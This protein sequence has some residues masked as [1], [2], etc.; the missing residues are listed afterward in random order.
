M[1]L[2]RSR[3]IAEEEA[4][5]S[6]F[7][8]PVVAPIPVVPSFDRDAGPPASGLVGNAGRQTKSCVILR[9]RQKDLLFR[10][11]PDN[12]KDSG[13][14]SVGEASVFAVAGTW[15]AGVAAWFGRDPAHTPRPRER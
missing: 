5:A 6:A 9:R 8:Y 2:D 14:A 3:G 11:H 10:R 7:H 15:P 13:G 4:G 1:G 12:R